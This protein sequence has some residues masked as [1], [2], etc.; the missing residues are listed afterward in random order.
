MKIKS[1]LSNNTEQLVIDSDNGCVQPFHG[2]EDSHHSVLCATLCLRLLLYPWSWVATEMTC[3][4]AGILHFNIKS[5][6]IFIQHSEKRKMWFF[7]GGCLYR[8]T[9][10]CIY[11]F[12][13]CSLCFG[14][15][16]N[17]KSPDSTQQL[18]FT[19]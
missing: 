6:S 16:S 3:F 13:Y 15:K 9:S 8:F 4:V 19:M 7:W 18:H 1:F 12:I 11:L 14:R 2:H 5:N 17:S 10:L